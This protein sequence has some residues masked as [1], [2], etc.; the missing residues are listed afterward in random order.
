MVIKIHKCCAKIKRTNSTKTSISVKKNKI[1][2]MGM[3]N[4]NKNDKTYQEIDNKNDNT[5]LYEININ[6]NMRKN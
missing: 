5:C 1:G 3:D 6:Y 2:Q 4:C